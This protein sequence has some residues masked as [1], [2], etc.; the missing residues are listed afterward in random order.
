[1]NTKQKVRLIT[2]VLMCVQLV[3]LAV[4][5]V[6]NLLKVISISLYGWLW[7]AIAFYVT[8]VIFYFSVKDL[9]K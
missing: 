7:L 2:L 8:A 4:L 3:I 1:M 6:L 9:R 5:A